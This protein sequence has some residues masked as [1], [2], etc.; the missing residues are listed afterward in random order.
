MLH[1]PLHGPGED[2]RSFGGIRKAALRRTRTPDAGGSET[3]FLSAFL[4]ARVTAMRQEVAHRDVSRVEEE[5]RRFLRE[6]NV[7]LDLPLAWSTYG[8]GYAIF[9]RPDSRC[10]EAGST[11][12]RPEDAFGR[13]AIV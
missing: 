5:Q 13:A 7:D 8:D 12:G 9:L 11:D 6:G 4:D 1:R 10:P 2:A 3:D